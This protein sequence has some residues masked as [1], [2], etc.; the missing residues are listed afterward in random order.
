MS[1]PWSSF[2]VIN[3]YI[4]APSDQHILYSTPLPR[5]W[6]A[7]ENLSPNSPQLGGT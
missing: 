2:Q 5:L 6:L 4:D 3:L 7:A 1:T